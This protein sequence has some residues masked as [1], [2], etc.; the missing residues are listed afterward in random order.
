MPDDENARKD[1]Q[2]SE[3][4]TATTSFPLKPSGEAVVTYLD[5]PPPS[6]PRSIHPRRPAPLVPTHEERTGEGSEE[7]DSKKPPS[8]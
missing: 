6:G 4:Q 3:E 2:V 7:D 5:S 1:K 8:R